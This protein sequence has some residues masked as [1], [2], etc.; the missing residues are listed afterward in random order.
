MPE[1]VQNARQILLLVADGLG[2]LQLE[3]RAQL[4]PN[5]VGLTGGPITSVVPSTTATALPL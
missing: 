5:L 2:W 3:D 1:I 4:A